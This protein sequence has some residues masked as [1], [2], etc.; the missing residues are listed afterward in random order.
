MRIVVALGGNALLRR[1][2]SLT[3]AVQRKNARIAANSLA[4]V[5]RDHHIVVAHGN[6]PQVGLL[7]LQTVAYKEA[8]PS[9]LDVLN[10]QTEGMIGYLIEQE[11][12]NALPTDTR[13]GTLLTMIEVDPSDPA[14]D[15]PTKPIGP[16]Y[17]AEEARRIG[18]EMGWRFVEEAPGR[19]R[20]VVPSPL[21]RHILESATIRYMVDAEIVVICA[22]GG[23]IPTRRSQDGSFTG[24]E[25]VIDKDRAA[26][27]L[28]TEVSA[29]ALLMLT[30]VEAVFHDWG[31][32]N[33]KPIRRATPDELD[34]KQFAPGTM[35][36]KVEAACAFVRTT[37]AIA[38]I[39][40]LEDARAILDGMAGTLIRAQAPNFNAAA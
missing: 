11:L 35:G 4:E 23:G 18:D 6:G 16:I 1:G 22:G 19:W 17:S 15:N 3:I 13:F 5:A 38:G 12:M 21:P 24:V 8:E 20:R 37:G 26:G 29:D 36:P 14:F 28:A 10:A 32:P 7:A 39:G 25:A 40:R 31:T 34:S 9:P 2:E 30:D 33:Q 27:L